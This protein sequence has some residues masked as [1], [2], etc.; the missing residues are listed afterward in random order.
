MLVVADAGPEVV[1][2]FV[3]ARQK[4]SAETKLSNPRSSDPAFDAP[5]ILFD[6][7]VDVGAGPVLDRLPS[8]VRMARG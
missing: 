5:V 3:V 2:E 4:R 8:V 1:A 6:P 7:V